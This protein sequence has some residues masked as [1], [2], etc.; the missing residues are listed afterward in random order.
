MSPSTSATSTPVRR[1]GG[2]SARVQEA[3]H[4]A[5]GRLMG[6]TTRDKITLRQVA[7]RAGVNPTS[8]YR[9]WGDI[10]TL[11]EE[12]AVAALTRDG[13][14]IPD[15]GDLT[16]DLNDWAGIIAEDIT[17]PQRVR[18][19]RAMVSARDLQVD[20]C[21]CMDIRQ[22]QAELMINRAIERGEPAPTSQQVLDHVVSPLYH[23]VTFGLPVDRDYAVRLVSDVRA[24]ASALTNAGR[25]EH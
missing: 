9:R 18:Y 23:R 21:P 11:M 14:V 8:V 1:P 15:H 2:R 3:V 7:E 19:L 22:Q 6:E 20:N 13:D 25:R 12:V 5:L 16:A 4:T 10:D 24:M 17:R